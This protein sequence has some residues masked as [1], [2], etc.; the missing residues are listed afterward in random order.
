MLS[1]D[2]FLNCAPP[3]VLAVE[4][5]ELTGTAYVRALTAGERDRFEVEHTK[6]ADKDFRARLA[7]ATLCDQ[8]GGLLFA[9][10]DIPRLSALPASVL[11]PIVQ[12]AVKVNRL[13][14]ADIED[15]RKN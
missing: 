8:E 7:A 10:S 5:P 12:A 14:A 6:S 15:L 2:S 13:G 4:V 1:R 9:P 11:E 3:K